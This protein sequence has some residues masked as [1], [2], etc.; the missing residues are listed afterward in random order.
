MFYLLN[1]S[2]IIMTGVAIW[3]IPIAKLPHF[4]PCIKWVWL[5]KLAAFCVGVADSVCAFVGSLF[6]LSLL[7]QSEYYFPLRWVSNAQ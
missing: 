7:A 1:Y 4:P 6:I 5:A 2:V 3:P